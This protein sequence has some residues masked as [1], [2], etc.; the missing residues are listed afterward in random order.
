[1]KF[2]VP[3]EPDLEYLLVLDFEATC[4]KD[5]KINPCPEI[6]EFPVFA[7]DIKKR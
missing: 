6:I 2:F 7:I 3:V 1:V 5:Q 4:I